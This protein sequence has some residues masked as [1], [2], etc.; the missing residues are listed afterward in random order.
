[1]LW[2]ATYGATEMMMKRTITI[3]PRLTA[4]LRAGTVKIM[5]GEYCHVVDENAAGG[6]IVL[7]QFDFNEDDT[8][9]YL[10]SHPT[11]DTW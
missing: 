2:Y 10:E 5:N 6:I 1:M 8:E 4:L 11:P 7:G 3:G 9:R